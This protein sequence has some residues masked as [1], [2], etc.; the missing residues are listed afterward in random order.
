[1]NW[2]DGLKDWA[3]KM[4]RQLADELDPTPPAPPPPPAPVS[5]WSQRDLD[6]WAVRNHPRME[7]RLVPV[8]SDLTPQQK[9][10]LGLRRIQYVYGN[11]LPPL[12]LTPYQAA[13]QRR[14]YEGKLP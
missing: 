14:R 5:Q 1:M 8:D 11:H 13:T 2:V 6:S 7:W 12:T 9:I 4:L 3:A 10:E